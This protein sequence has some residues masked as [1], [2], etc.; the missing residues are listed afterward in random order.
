MPRALTRL[1]LL[2]PLSTA[3]PARDFPVPSVDFAALSSSVHNAHNVELL[4]AFQAHGILSLRNVPQYA[5][6]RR[7]YLRTAAAC[8]VHAQQH[9]A[10]F[11]LHRQLRDGTHRYTVSLESG[12]RLSQS[13]T[14]SETLLALCPEYLELHA[15]F[16]AVVEVAVASVGTALDATQRF[17]V[18]TEQGTAAMTARRLLEDA[19]HLDHFHAYEAVKRQRRR[20]G[21]E[22]E[23]NVADLTLELHTDNG[24]M[25]AMSAP[26]YFEVGTTGK[27][28]HKDTQAQDAGLVI[29]TANGE[30]VRPVLQPDELVLMMGSG[31]HTW[32]QTTP[33]LPSVLHGMRYPRGISWTP[34][35]E[36]G[37]HKLLRAWFGKMILLPAHQTMDNTGL[38]FG[39]YANQTTRYLVEEANHQAFAAVA[40]PP[41]RRLVASANSCALKICSLKSSASASNLQSSCQITCNHDSSKD[42]ALCQQYCDCTPSTSSATTCWMLCVENLSSDACPGEQV[43]N[44]AATKEQLAMKCVAAPV[45]PPPPSSAP[46]PPTPPSDN[47]NADSAPSAP[48]A[49]STPST[50][51][52]PSSVSPPSPPSTDATLPPPNAPSTGGADAP[53][54][55]ALLE[56]SSSSPSAAAPV[57]SATTSTSPS[58]ATAPTSTTLTKEGANTVSSTATADSTSAVGDTS[59]ATTGASASRS[60]IASIADDTSSVASAPSEPSSPPSASPLPPSP[61]TSRSSSA[62]RVVNSVAFYVHA[63]SMLLAALVFSSIP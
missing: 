21:D 14:E 36:Q 15:A 52:T 54:S 50:P 58:L 17:H 59:N 49:A 3:L 35:G 45:A 8:A 40:C 24:L 2:L 28:Q 25:I 1:L 5:T 41:Q 18:W 16:S 43:C 47:G 29:K 11:L 23:G 9:G 31:I 12:Y 53:L 62:P 32:I 61:S 39:Q 46:A 13:L 60:S 63:S 4:A 42:A 48:A 44:T 22:S 7:E 19:V 10:D 26:E 57:T 20:L 27:L 55:G 30:I 6:L 37:N 51:S 38:T 56:S 33:A 34:D